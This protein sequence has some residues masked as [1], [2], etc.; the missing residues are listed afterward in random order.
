MPAS[1]YV[2]KAREENYQIGQVHMIYDERSKTNPDGTVFCK[3][4]NLPRWLRHEGFEV[5]IDP[6]GELTTERGL[7]TKEAAAV[8]GI[9]AGAVTSMA[10][11]GKLIQ[12]EHED[13]GRAFLG[14]QVEAVAALRRK[15]RPAPAKKE[16]SAVE[17]ARN[18]AS[19]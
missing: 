4:P 14:S 13:L 5:I 6:S 9:P 3:R 19:A 8:L 1:F 2:L 7:T 12:F 11:S 18:D 17:S 10:R 15:T 16:V